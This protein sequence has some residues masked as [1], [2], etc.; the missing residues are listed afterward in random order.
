MRFRRAEKKDLPGVTR[1][2]S[3]VLEV[4]ADARPDLF[5][6]GTRKYTDG[7]LLRIFSD[8]QTPVFVA[9]ED[10]G[11]LVAHCFCELQEQKGLNNMYDMRTLYID[12]LCVDE[13]ARGTHVGSALYRHVL[14]FAKEQGCYNVT[15]NVWEGNDRARAFYEHM[16]FGVRK[17]MME[18]IL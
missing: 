13:A 4:H 8:P 10:G 3:Q 2:L 11:A 6:H 12:D 9:E 7:E 17:T 1:L 15:L 16:G 18:K 14:E 5:I